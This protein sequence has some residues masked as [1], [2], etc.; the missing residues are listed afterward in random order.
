MCLRPHP[1]SASNELNLWLELE[2]ADVLSVKLD[3]LERTDGKDALGG[4]DLG[5]ST[6]APEAELLHSGV[7]TPK[8][9][10]QTSMEMSG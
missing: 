5:L 7:T 9:M 6:T 2:E 3:L 8:I 4:F 10:S 1:G